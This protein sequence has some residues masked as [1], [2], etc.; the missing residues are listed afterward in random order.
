[1][2]VCMYVTAGVWVVSQGRGQA[3]ARPAADSERA[4]QQLHRPRVE[5]IHPCGRCLRRWVRDWIV[6]CV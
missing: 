4:P 1:M 5:Q 6:L 2:Y 3:A